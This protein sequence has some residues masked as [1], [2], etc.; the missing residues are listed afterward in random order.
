MR[1]ITKIHDGI[2]PLR[3]ATSFTNQNPFMTLAMLMCKVFDINQDMVIITIDQSDINQEPFVV[4][5]AET[6]HFFFCV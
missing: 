1:A 3:Q 4:V 5:T 2:S 6:W